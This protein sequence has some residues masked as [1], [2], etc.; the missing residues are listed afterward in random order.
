MQDFYRLVGEFS[1]T[2]DK[3]DEL[4]GLVLQLLDKCGI[5]KLKEVEQFGKK[6]TVISQLKPDADGIVSFDYCI[7]EKKKRNISTYNIN[8]CEL[9]VNDCGYCE[10]GVAIMLVLTL[11]ESY[12]ASRCCLFMDK[13]IW[14]VNSNAKLIEHML[15]VQLRFP[16]RADILGMYMFAKEY[17]K[18]DISAIKIIDW[19]PFDFE[20]LNLKQLYA[21]QSVSKMGNRRYEF[22]EEYAKLIAE[23]YRA[24]TDKLYF[25]KAI[26]RKNEDELL[27]IWDDRELQ[28]SNNMLEAIK[29]WKEQYSIIEIGNDFEM[30]IE[31]GRILQDLKEEWDI[32]Y[33]EE[34]FIAEFME[35]KNDILHKKLLLL[36]RSIMDKSFTYYPELTRWQAFQWMVKFGRDE[37]ETIEIGGLLKVLTNKKLRNE[38]FG[39]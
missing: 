27:G 21:L 8:T 6:M 37:F 26:Q 1:I 30:E 12:S 5:R 33:V 39:L 28:L 22:L 29:K 16:F 36:L 15:N 24:V 3:K 38:I 31:M 18:E 4:N 20:E 14:N 10:F 7:F 17:F 13:D 9:I 23:S 19:F 35:N 25:L 34:E 11:K 2:E 32:E